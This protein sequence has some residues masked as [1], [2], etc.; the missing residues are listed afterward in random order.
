MAIFIIPVIVIVIFMV[1]I[2][3][4]TTILSVLLCLESSYPALLIILLWS[5]VNMQITDDSIGAL[6]MLPPAHVA[7]TLM[8]G[9]VAGVRAFVFEGW[10]I[11]SCLFCVYLYLEIGQA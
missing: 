4:I 3:T 8:G 9:R 6:A 11:F 2:S 5:L 7:R 10:G 1:I